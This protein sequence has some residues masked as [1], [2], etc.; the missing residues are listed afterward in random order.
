MNVDEKY[1]IEQLRREEMER[2]PNL[3]FDCQNC[4]VA[5][6]GFD[7]SSSIRYDIYE[8][9]GFCPVTE[10]FV[11]DSDTDQDNRCSEFEAL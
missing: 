4:N 9:V 7:I 8:S 1:E 6:D 10:M 5:G 11:S 3:C 2:E